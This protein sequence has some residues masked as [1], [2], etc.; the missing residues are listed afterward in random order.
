MLHGNSVHIVNFTLNIRPTFFFFP[1][2][3]SFFPSLSHT[4]KHTFLIFFLGKNPPSIEPNTNKQKSI[5]TIISFL[6]FLFPFNFSQL[7]KITRKKNI[8]AILQTC[9][10]LP[11]ENFWK[12]NLTLK[13]EWQRG[14]K[15]EC[16]SIVF[17]IFTCTD[18][19]FK[20]GQK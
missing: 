18:A 2:S 12:K 3:F 17:L 15:V 20:I 7:H 8:S 9:Y 10:K 5:N 13:R 1:Q 4:Y 19:Y 14:E 6:L 16:F 11:S